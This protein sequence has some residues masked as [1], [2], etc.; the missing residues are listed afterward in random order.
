MGGTL[1]NEFVFKHR[2]RPK[3]SKRRKKIIKYSESNN[4]NNKVNFLD[5]ILESNIDNNILNQKQDLEDLN[6]LKSLSEKN[7]VKINSKEADSLKFNFT[8]VKSQNVIFNKLLSE[9]IYNNLEE[10]NNSFNEEEEFY[11]N[12][13]NKNNENIEKKKKELTNNIKSIFLDSKIFSRESIGDTSTSTLSASNSISN[14]FSSLSESTDYDIDYELEF[15]RN[16]NDIRQSYLAKLITKKIWNP[17]NNEKKFNSIIIFDW[18]DTLLPTSF[19]SPG[20]NFNANM[21]LS[22]DDYTKLLKIEK[23]VLEL[24]TKAIEKGDV[25]IITNAGKGWVEFSSK[26][27]YPSIIDILSKIKI[28]SAREEYE[29]IFPG[30]SRKWK[31]QAFLNLQKYV[32]VKLVTNLICLG[33]SSFEIEAGRILASKFSEA[34]I[35][36]IK[37]KEIPKLDDL[38]KQLNA[39]CNQFNYIYSTVK[40]LTIRVEKKRN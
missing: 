30:D 31:I 35:K 7:L 21:K 15:Y 3:K 38:I 32:D 1:S 6:E 25:Y 27:Y 5:N 37:F 12:E 18:D 34:F 9:D 2:K 26:L 4:Q 39:V 23:K 8:S 10:N 20:G 28:I 14:S 29:K 17:N 19:L 11:E 16:G 33:D 24:L 13:D 36:T 22:K 40:N